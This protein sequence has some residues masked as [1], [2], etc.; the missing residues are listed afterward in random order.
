MRKEAWRKHGRSHVRWLSPSE[1]PLEDVSY[2]KSGAHHEVANA[3][4]SYIE[5][6][7]RPKAEMVEAAIAIAPSVAE[8]TYGGGED[9]IDILIDIAAYCGPRQAEQLALRSEDIDLATRT[10][11]I[12][13]RWKYPR[14][15]RKYYRQRFTKTEEIRAIP[16]RASL[17]ERLAARVAQ[18]RVEAAERREAALAA[19]VTGKELEL[20]STAW[21][22]PH[23]V[24]GVPP[25]K[26]QFN[27]LWLKIRQ[28]LEDDGVEWPRKIKFMNL[29][30]HFATWAYEL[31]SD[32]ETV[33]LLM[34]DDVQTV[35]D[36]YVLP[37]ADT[38]DK[39]RAAMLKV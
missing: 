16:Y 13:G 4:R 22:F 3:H 32:W 2:G 14:D 39:V 24:H 30:H 11:Y 23:K 5:P 7:H 12:N 10:I 6:K 37:S 17:H 31:M 38:M 35:K 29:R 21:L 20:V 18:A 27:D 36:H 15:G 33:A 9:W 8:G 34:G 19:G 1:N 26:E 28:A 25:T